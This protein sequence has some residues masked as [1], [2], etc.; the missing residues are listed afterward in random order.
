[1]TMPSGETG[2][3][4]DG[5][6][7]IKNV[8][9]FLDAVFLQ[10]DLW[11]QNR[12]PGQ[13]GIHPWFRGEPV[14][15]QPLM[16]KLYRRSPPYGEGD[17][18]HHFRNQGIGHG[19][20]AGIDRDATDLWLCLARHSGLPTRLLDWTEGALTALF[21]AAREKEAARVWMLVP[22]LL[23]MRSGL[24]GFEVPWH[25]STQ[26][27]ASIRA[28]WADD[29]PPDQPAL[30]VAMYPMHIHARLQ[31]QHS[32]FTI[33]GRRKESINVLMSEAGLDHGLRSIEIDPAYHSAILEEL[34][35]L[36]TSE[37]SIFPDLDGLASDLTAQFWTPG[38][39]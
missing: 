26:T 1:M 31:V 29:E 23:N 11:H 34:R 19:I 14:V 4:S 20:R 28:A 35:I 3:T 27:A 15:K 25:P 6:H 33:H 17:L 36:G 18:L 12:P 8:V 32:C 2:G 5:S 7:L 37:A 10:R 30:P 16:P 24:A 38:R 9:Q 22:Q 13:P 39:W 21:F